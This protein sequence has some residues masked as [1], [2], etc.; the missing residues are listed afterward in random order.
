MALFLPAGSIHIVIETILDPEL[1]EALGSH[2]PPAFSLPY[3]LF[4]GFFLLLASGI[5]DKGKGLP[6]G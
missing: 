1:P 2:Q 4:W 3:A 6:L 5:Q